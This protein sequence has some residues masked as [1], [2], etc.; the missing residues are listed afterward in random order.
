MSNAPASGP[1]LV[2]QHT[3]PR[4]KTARAK[5]RSRGPVASLNSSPDL[6]TTVSGIGRPSRATSLS[7]ATLSCRQA[8]V[9]NGDANTSVT[10]LSRASWVEM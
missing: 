10:R 9:R 3:P 6:T 1:V 4:E 2:R 7:N 8:S 5:Y